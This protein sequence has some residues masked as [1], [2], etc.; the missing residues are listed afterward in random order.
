[1]TAINYIAIAD[2]HTLQITTTH[3][4]SFQSA[5]FN[6]RSLVTVSNSGD[7][8]AFAFNSL[9]AGSQMRRLSL[10]FTDSLTTD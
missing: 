3:A 1:V 5:V 10:L 4:K 9:P 8:S 2:L 7:T 6:D